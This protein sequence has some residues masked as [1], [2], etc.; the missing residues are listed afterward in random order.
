MILFYCDFAKFGRKYCFT[1]VI[2][3]TLQKGKEIC[4]VTKNKETN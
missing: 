2:Q 1:K 4:F 3:Y